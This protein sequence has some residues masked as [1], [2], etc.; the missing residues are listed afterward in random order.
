MYNIFDEEIEEIEDEAINIVFKYLSIWESPHKERN[1]SVRFKCQLKDAFIVRLQEK[2][3]SHKRYQTSSSEV[4]L[5]YPAV[6]AGQGSLPAERDLT[7]LAAQDKGT[8]GT[9]RS[10]GREDS[11]RYKEL[12]IL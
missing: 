8:D 1:N 3:G 10:Q 7:Q 6:C 9:R 11:V 4:D 12:G 2:K 5:G